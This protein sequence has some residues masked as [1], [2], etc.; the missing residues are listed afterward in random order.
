MAGDDAQ[1]GGC[2]SG[3]GYDR[4][5]L[6]VLRAGF[7]ARGLRCVVFAFVLSLAFGLALCVVLRF[8]TT[9][10]FFLALLLILLPRTWTWGAAAAAGATAAGTE[11]WPPPGAGLGPPLCGIS[12]SGPILSLSLHGS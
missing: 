10:R 2:G 7:F 4:P 5:R 11:T 1:R 8:L 12:Y 6:W 9:L 3:H